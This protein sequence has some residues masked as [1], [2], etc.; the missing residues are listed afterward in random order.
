MGAKEEKEEEEEEEEEEDLIPLQDQTVFGTGIK[1]KRVR[2]VPAQSDPPFSAN[3]ITSKTGDRYLSIVLRDLGLST[4]GKSLGDG[5]EEVS[6]ATFQSP[7]TTS[8]NSA[9]RLCEICQLPIASIERNPI[10]SAKPHE[11]SLAHQVC[12]SHSHPPSHIDRRRLGLKCLS[13]YGWDPDSRLGLGAIGDGIRVPIKVKVK[14]N[15]LGLG[16][17]ENGA[18]QKRPEKTEKLDARQVRHK[19]QELRRKQ[20]KLQELFYRNDDVEKYLGSG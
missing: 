8:D 3:P 6:E 5:P 17:K 12:L 2:F 19:E 13:S 7:L 18:I 11:A 20:Q 14:N 9:E 4:A 16:I 1:R 10:S 15:T